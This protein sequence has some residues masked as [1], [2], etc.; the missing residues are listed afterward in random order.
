M[1]GYSVVVIGKF[2]EK[3]L[4]R[5]PAYI[6]EHFL[7]WV[8][9]VHEVGVAEMRKLSGYHDE[10]LRGKRE[11]ERSVRLTKS[12]RV[13]YIETRNDEITIL[14]VQEINKHEY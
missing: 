4:R 5:L 2:A 13:I 11:G 3:Q 1:E 8:N 6:K 7:V 9:T 12:Y 14:S 10:P